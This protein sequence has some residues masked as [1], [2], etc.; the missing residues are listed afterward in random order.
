M[1]LC[2]RSSFFCHITSPKV[3]W[4]LPGK[5]SGALY[6]S[7]N[8]NSSKNFSPVSSIGEGGGDSGRKKVPG[9]G[10]RKRRP[11]GTSRRSVI[12]KSFSQEQ[13]VF[14]TPVGDDPVVGIIGGGISGL[15]CALTLEKRGIR[16]T[17]FDTGVHGLGGRMGTRVVDPDPLVF[18]HAAQFFTVTDPRFQVFVDK[19]IEEGLVREW[20]GLLGNLEVGGEFIPLPPSPARYVGT[21]GMRPLADSILRDSRMVNVVRPCWISK[22]EPFNGSWHL[23]EN[24]KPHGHFDSIV[25]SH[26][27][28]CANRLL[29]TSGLPLLASQMKRLELSSIWALLAAFKEPLIRPNSN[30]ALAFEGAFVKGIDSVSW[31]GNNS[32][33]LFPSKN[34][35]P[36]CWTFFSTGSYGRKN[37]VPQENVPKVTADKVTREMLSGAEVALGLSEGSLKPFY[38][39]V[40]L[41]GAALPTNTPDVPCIY[42]PCGRAGIC[43][44]WLLGSS[45]EAAVLSGI[46]LGEHIANF[47]SSG[48]SQAEEFSIGLHNSFRPLDGHDIGQFP[49]LSSLWSTE[50]IR[51]MV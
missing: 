39:R 42:D 27:G 5:A 21:K 12:K 9:K 30:G 8:T 38:T 28:K 24:G 43:G 6:S 50:K 35:I 40:Q 44:D 51:T 17:V 31:M 41:W 26:N 13:V 10:P 49:G 3:N 22:I 11:Y 36:H 15:I 7:Y 23:T 46:S 25:I 34:D 18:D 4:A 16:S 20:K 37:K 47:F 14:T 45:I 2:L 29:S 19:W 33:K 1:A 48:G 32:R